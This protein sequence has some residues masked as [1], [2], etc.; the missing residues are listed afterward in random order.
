[1]DYAL[2]EGALAVGVATPGSLAGGPPST[3]LSY[4]LEAAASAIVFALPLDPAYIEPYLAKKDR[5]SHERDYFATDAAAS[6]VAFQMANLVRQMGYEAA[7]V[8]SNFVYRAEGRL[9]PDISLRFLAAAS[10]V[11]LLGLSGNLLTP[12]HGPDVVLAGVVTSIALEPTSPLAPEE[13]YCDS[14]GLCQAA[15]ASGLMSAREL[16]RVSL[17]GREHTYAKRLNYMRCEFVCGGFTGLHPSGKWSTWS[18]AR[19]EVPKRDEDFRPALIRAA[20][21]FHQRPPL[22]G[23]RYNH[24]VR[25]RL[26]LTCGN[27][28]LVCHPEKKVRARR[29]KLL[30]ASGVLV[31]A[32]DGKLAAVSPREARARLEAMEPERRAL[33]E[34]ITKEDKK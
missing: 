4:L 13:N 12:T 29:Y 16:A 33:Y 19:F 31:Q 5:R 26:G 6:G 28:M 8:A 21:L 23:G 20:K 30:T 11:G 22:D 15:C 14:C 18:P 32:P 1:M 27:C 3:D 34:N 24:M 25:A 7:P 17:G 9:M 2:G 10:G